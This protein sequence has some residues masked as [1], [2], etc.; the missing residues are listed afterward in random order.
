MNPPDSVTAY[1]NALLL[2]LQMFVRAV[3]D[4]SDASCDEDGGVSLLMVERQ[5]RNNFIVECDP[6]WDFLEI[7]RNASKK[8]LNKNL[9]TLCRDGK[10]FRPR[11]RPGGGGGSRDVCRPSTQ[12]GRLWTH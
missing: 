8:A 6:S 5:I 3:R 12:C 7:L 4:A 9:V 1:T 2:L 10:S 11:E